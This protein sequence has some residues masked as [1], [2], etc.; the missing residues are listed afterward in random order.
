MALFDDLDT[1]GAGVRGLLENPALTR[2]AA[3]R[4]RP[5][6]FGDYASAQGSLWDQHGATGPAG[7]NLFA[8][9]GLGGDPFAQ[10][11]RPVYGSAGSSYDRLARVA[12]LALGHASPLGAAVGKGAK[13][14][15]A[16]LGGAVTSQ[17]G[18]P[19]QGWAA[20]TTQQLDAELAGSPL[21][22]QGATIAAIAARHGVPVTVAMGILRQESS[23]GR[24]ATGNNYGGLMNADG[25]HTLAQFGS[26]ADGLD[27]VIGNMGTGLYRGKSIADF[28]NTYAPP[29]DG[30][31]TSGY[32]NNILALDHQWGGHS[33]WTTV[34][35]GAPQAPAPQATTQGGYAFPVEGYTGKVALHWGESAN[36]A[37]IMAPEGTNILSLGNGVVQDAS[38]NNLGGWTVTMRLD[39]GQIVYMAHMRQQPGVQAGQRVQAGQLLG[40]VGT[41]GNAAG[42]PSHLHLGIGSDI[43]S[44]SGPEGGAGVPW[45][46]GPYDNTVGLLNWILSGQQ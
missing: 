45:G 6:P 26:V 46:T 1:L 31:D 14:V 5:Q 22:G 35:T 30:N 12:S 3:N 7:G 15:A 9:A 38:W 20:P 17:T 42:G 16:T 25:S 19:G 41:T 44:G 18:T 34:V 43:K 37:D 10:G 13:A 39:S 27:A 28:M 8:Q 32:I 36:A 29:D 11:T 23:Y 40:Q 21:A 4:E 24:H 2:L 33:D